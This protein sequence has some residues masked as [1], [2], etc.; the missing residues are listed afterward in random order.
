[1][2]S[3]PKSN[4]PPFAAGGG[5]AAPPF[6]GEDPYQTLDDLM[7]VVE[8]LCPVWSPRAVFSPDNVMLM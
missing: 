2:T 3:L 7:S 4:D 8:A 1:M 6:V 5:L